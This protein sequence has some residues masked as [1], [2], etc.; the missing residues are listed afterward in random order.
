LLAGLVAGTAAGAAA[1]PAQA[2]KFSFF[3]FGD[4]VADAY[5]QMDKDAE[6]QYSPFPNP[7]TSDY[8]N[9]Q[10]NAYVETNKARVSKIMDV[11][12]VKVPKYIALKD[13]M[14]VNSPLTLQGGFLRTSMEYVSCGDVTLH[15]DQSEQAFKSYQQARKVFQRLA[16]VKAAA[17]IKNFDAAQVEYD[18]AM[19]EYT[20]WKDFVKF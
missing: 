16:N 14:S 15:C 12:T 1:Q 6:T 7:A 4:G 2:I 20:V 13:R 3:G 18:A 9:N 17:E 10:K 19:R 11:I 5:N 8:N